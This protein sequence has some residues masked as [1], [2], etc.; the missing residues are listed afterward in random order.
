MKT[1]LEIDT[2]FTSYIITGNDNYMVHNYTN[3]GLYA[4][5][6][7]VM[8]APALPIVSTVLASGAIVV[9]HPSGPVC[10]SLVLPVPFLSFCYHFVVVV[11]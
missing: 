10:P 8:G 4:S 9:Y 7:V 11:V 3:N 2:I 1:L 6:L 5:F